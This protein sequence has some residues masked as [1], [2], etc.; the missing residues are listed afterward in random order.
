MKTFRSIKHL[1]SYCEELGV[2]EGK[3]HGIS[4]VSGTILFY[5]DKNGKVI[6]KKLNWEGISH[7]ETSEVDE[8]LINEFFPA[9]DI[10]VTN[11][12]LGKPHIN[13]P[14]IQED[15]DL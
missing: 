6:K 14:E 2:D 11:S 8:F 15:I 7:V 10:E 5:S 4:G 3:I 12:H 13:K 9:N 1:V